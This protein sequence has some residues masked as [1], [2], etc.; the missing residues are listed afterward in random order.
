M[1]IPS[2][3]L[4]AASLQ[5]HAGCL[6]HGTSKCIAGTAVTGWMITYLQQHSLHSGACIVVGTGCVGMML[7]PGLLQA[8]LLFGRGGALAH[9]E[10]TCGA[11]SCYV[12]S[13][14]QCIML[15]EPDHLASGAVAQLVVLPSLESNH[16]IMCLLTLW[17]LV[18]GT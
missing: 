13:P 12:R 6:T 18:H 10:C 3:A 15:R 16:A 17:K 1:L 11:G 7:L 9:C 5:Q 14:L 4:S 8:E 2:S